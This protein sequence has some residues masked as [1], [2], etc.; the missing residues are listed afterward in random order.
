VTAAR[1]GAVILAAGGSAR[2]GRPKQLLALDGEPLVRRAARA[3]AGAGYAPVVV[4]VGAAAN[5]VS[6][7]LEADAFVVVENP[8][9]RAGVAGSIRRGVA[10]LLERRPEVEGVLL[11]VCDQPAAGA[12]HLAALADALADG[13]HAVA[14]SSY[15][16]TVGVPALFARSTF[17]ELEALE[18]DQGAK[19]VVTRDPARVVAVAL[20]GGERD[21]DTE[22]D[23]SGQRG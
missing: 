5:E 6:A 21:V 15:A 11:A 1:H 4:V 7:A 22:A 3:A 10:A 14:A 13:A 8:G 23:W 18:G 12:A 2:L 16:G 17:G 9:W 20:P 19:R